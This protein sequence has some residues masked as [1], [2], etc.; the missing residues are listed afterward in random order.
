MSPGRRL[1]S[2]RTADERTPALASLTAGRPGCPSDSSFRRH[3]SDLLLECRR[4]DDKRRRRPMATSS[5][6]AATQPEEDFEQRAS[7]AITAF[8]GKM[9]FVYV[10]VGA[11]AVWIGTRGFGHDAFPFNFLTMAVSLEAIFL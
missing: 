8:C 6:R 3:E 11:F 2:A 9:L 1:G 10:H 5:A 4:H 7:D